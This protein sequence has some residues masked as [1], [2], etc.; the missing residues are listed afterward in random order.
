MKMRV[1]ICFG[2]RTR[3]GTLFTEKYSLV[4]SF[5]LV[6]NKKS[7]FSVESLYHKDST[8]SRPPN[9]V[10]PCSAAGLVLGWVTKYEYPVL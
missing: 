4:V 5:S 9:K 6:R 8:M 1:I 7:P 2:D 10:K 3:S